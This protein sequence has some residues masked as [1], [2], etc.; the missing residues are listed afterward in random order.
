MVCGV[1][2]MFELITLAGT[3]QGRQVS[4]TSTQDLGNGKVKYT[5]EVETRPMFDHGAGFLYNEQSAVRIA[6][7]VVM[8][9]GTILAYLCYSGFETSLFADTEEGGPLLGSGGGAG[10]GGQPLGQGYRLGNSG[11]YSS[12]S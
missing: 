5:T 6:S 3:V 12:N 2:S 1:Q 7:P 8:L 9:L 10:G 4:H 11:F